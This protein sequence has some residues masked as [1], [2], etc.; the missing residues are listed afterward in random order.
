MKTLNELIR[1]INTWQSKVFTQATA[2]SAAVHLKREADELVHDLVNY[3]Y[4][5][6]AHEIA[7]VFILLAAVTHLSGIDLEEAVEGKMKINRARKWGKP[8]AQ[9]V[10]E[11]IRDL[12]KN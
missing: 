12:G 2:Q 3:D 7:D 4:D 9:G 11:H 10:V 6:A 5:N 1:E 8:D